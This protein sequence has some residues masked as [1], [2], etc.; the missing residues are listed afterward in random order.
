M[1]SQAK[2]A[3]SRVL[4]E[5]VISLSETQ[6]EIQKITKRRPDKA[7]LTRWIHRGVRGTRLE[8]VRLGNQIFTSRQAVTRFIEA[9]TAESFN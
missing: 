3:V 4:T 7:T 5:D 9:R 6:S 8:A 1:T 2:Q